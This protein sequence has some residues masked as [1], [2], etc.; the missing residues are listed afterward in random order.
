M[1]YHKY[2]STDDFMFRSFD[3]HSRI[4]RSSKLKDYFMISSG[5]NQL[6]MPAIWKESICMEIDTDY[7]YRWYTSSRGFQCVTSAVKV[8]ED[9]ISGL[10]MES[11]ARSSRDV[12]M[13]L[14]GCGAANAVFEYL[15][16]EYGDCCVILVGMNYSLYDRLAEKHDFRVIELRRSEDNDSIPFLS[17]FKNMEK[18]RVKEVYVF[19]IPNNPT[20]E[21]YSY[22]EFSDI[23]MEIKERSGFIIL[24]TV[25]SLAI[26]KQLKPFYES[27]ITIND[28]WDSCAVVNSFSKTD[29]AAGLRLG[30]VYSSDYIAKFCS[31]L[32]A[33]SIMN[34]PTF[35]AFPVV[36]ACM[37]RCMYISK[38]SGHLLMRNRFSEL[39][40]RL[41]FITSAGIPTKM[42]HYAEH[43]FSCSEEYCSNYTEENLSNERIILSNYNNSIEM[44]KPYIKKVSKFDGGFNFCV[45][46]S[47]SFNVGELELVKRLID[48]TGI[49]ILTESS[50][51][52]RNVNDN[53]YFIRFSS[54]CDRSLYVSALNRLIKFLESEGFER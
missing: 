7:L 31:C 42:K 13:T 23:I 16:S 6:P 37:F 15:K 8:Y 22:N 9:Y 33:S 12:C 38:V 10:S 35:P 11:F 39:F 46:F 41:F 24:D 4:F 29:S 20:G 27:L 30:Y 14:G 49:A 52:R 54:A 53:S 19:S 5:T 44:L 28:Y 48:T 50:F 47:K 1:T 51:S 2:H 3:L 21:I 32:N 43:I 26:T 40:R 18:C 34:P 17:D 45:W 36:L 25:C